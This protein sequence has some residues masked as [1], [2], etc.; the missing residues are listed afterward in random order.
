VDPQ[1]TAAIVFLDKLLADEGKLEL[2]AKEG[3][4]CG[5]AKKAAPC[6][7]EGMESLGLDAEGAALVALVA[8]QGSG[9]TEEDWEVMAETLNDGKSDPKSGEDWRLKWVAIAPGVQAKLAQDPDMPCGHTCSTCPTKDECHLHEAVD[10]E[11]MVFPR[12]PS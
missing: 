7:T 5:G 3:G 11:D 2:A 1:H 8:K 6:G 12:P 9:S 4:C 10:M